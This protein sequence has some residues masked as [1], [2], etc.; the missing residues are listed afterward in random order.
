MF[1]FLFIFIFYFTYLISL[2]Q[3]KR[4]ISGYIT[5]GETGEK[6]FGA[7]VFDTVSKLGVTTNDYGFFS[8]TI[9]KETALLRVGFYGLRTRYFSVDI[10]TNQLNVQ[11]FKI[12][13]L[14]EVTISADGINRQIDNTNTGTV[15]IQL[16][17]LDKLPLILGEKD[18]MRMIQLLPGV[19]SGGEASS[20]LYVRGGGPDQNLILLDGVPVYN[21][22]HL[23]G[24]FS[25][26]NS[27]AISNVSLIKGG[28]PA[29]YGG[30]VSSVLDMRMKEGN[31]KK[32]SVEGSLGLISSR[33]MV[34]GP[35][36]K[37]KTS[38]MIS[39][40]R[41]YLD[42]LVK[43]F[44]RNNPSQG[45][46]FFHD[47][48]TKIQHKINDKHHLYFSGYFGVDKAQINNNQEAY[49]DDAGNRFKNDNEFKLNWGNT[50]GAVRWNYKIS[51]K[52]FVNTTGTFSNYKF[53]IGREATQD[54]TNAFGD[55][56]KSIYTNGFSS[57]ILDWSIKSDFTF[58]PN[59]SHSI[60]FGF[61]E[62]YHTFTPGVSTTSI[63][64]STTNFNV[65]AGSRK[66]FS[67]ELG[68]YIE[69]DFKVGKN[70]K[71]NAGYRHS[72]F[73]IGNKVYHNPEPRV[74][75]NL[76][77]GEKSS[78]KAGIS[79]TAQYLHLLSNIGI[80]LPADLWVPATKEVEPV[81]AYQGS[82]GIYHE[83]TK[84]ISVSVEGY[85]KEMS[86]LIQYKD[87][88]DFSVDNGTNWE[89]TITTGN[90]TAYGWEL[91]VEK[92]KGNFSGWVGYTMSWS[93]RQFDELNNGEPFFHR[94]DRRHD[95]S[96][97]L[98]YDIT[99]KWDIGLIFVYGT[100]N[101]VTVGSQ[102][103]GASNYF[104][105]SFWG[106]DLINYASLNG[107]RMPAYH[108]LDLG[109][110]RKKEK[111]M[112]L[113]TLSLSIYNVYNRNNPFYI[114]KGVNKSNN[115]A[116]IGV[117]LFPIIPSISW[118]FKFDFEKMKEIKLNSIK[119]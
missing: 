110:N 99:E 81:V 4:T 115:P 55:V 38:F 91:L 71:V 112:G 61:V 35:I 52:L 36:K 32:Y 66:Q 11:L 30:R 62:T 16:D 79:R 44:I 90:G 24:F 54:K 26:F 13:E 1:R 15:E 25:I 86:N 111:K 94:Y 6:L 20:G 117:G 27:D 80:G 85:Y 92:K 93:I 41:T 118:N 69:D 96:I 76:R 39:G 116:L 78:L 103:Y 3:E 50:I 89:E 51:P 75:A 42:A 17:K 40:R 107:Y 49:Y 101:A 82:L 65:Q 9:P 10:E 98:S 7:A 21:A 29:R 22:S 77:L 19:K 64:D 2:G 5:H 70:L 56:S 14:S 87:G 114:Y 119:E 108:R 12:Q 53:F 33:L 105:Q 28:F 43:P 95:L 58:I 34:E 8:L 83:L 47:F 68:V 37:D 59:P 67:H 48:N 18:V 104:G 109:A 31:L 97:A 113:S 106:T 57:G 46:Y 72:F 23:F 102:G 45:G 60:K 73:V 100:G 88:A 63:T 84:T 74:N